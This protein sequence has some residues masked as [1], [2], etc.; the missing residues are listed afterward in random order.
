MTWSLT[1]TLL[2]G[3]VVIISEIMGIMVRGC[4]L[5]VSSYYIIYPLMKED[6][7]NIMGNSFSFN[8]IFSFISALSISYGSWSSSLRGRAC[9]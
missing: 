2:L 9:K 7:R 1:S 6:M 5:Q 8:Q 3:L 4:V